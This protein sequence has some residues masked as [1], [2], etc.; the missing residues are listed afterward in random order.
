MTAGIRNVGEHPYEPSFNDFNQSVSWLTARKIQLPCDSNQLQHCTQDGVDRLLKAWDIR[1]NAAQ[2][3]RIQPDVIFF[4]VACESHDRSIG[5]HR[6]AGGKSRK[7]R[8]HIEVR[9]RA[10]DSRGI[11][12][13]PTSGSLFKLHEFFRDCERNSIY[14][15]K[16]MDNFVWNRRGMQHPSNVRFRNAQC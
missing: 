12:Q 13:T 4:V 14:V 15:A 9:T 5:R 6:Q 16:S 7:Y 3:R 11:S 1:R 10:K 8:A 2:L